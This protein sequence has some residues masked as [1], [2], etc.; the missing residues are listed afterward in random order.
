VVNDR[1]IIGILTQ[2]ITHFCTHPPAVS[3]SSDSYGNRLS[4]QQALLLKTSL[5]VY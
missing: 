3:S 4:P 1:P 5:S 2:V